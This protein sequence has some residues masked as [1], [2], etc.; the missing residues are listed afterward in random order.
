MSNLKRT[1][2]RNLQNGIEKKIQFFIF[3]SAKIGRGNSIF[4]N[5]LLSNICICIFFFTI[6]YKYIFKNNNKNIRIV[7]L[8]SITIKTKKNRG[9]ENKSINDQMQRNNFKYLMKICFDFSN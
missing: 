7:Q 3:F 9:H 4:F 6:F 1:F 5:Y 2:T 8:Q